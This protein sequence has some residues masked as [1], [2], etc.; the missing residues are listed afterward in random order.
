MFCMQCGKEINETAKFCYSC[1][2]GQEIDESDIA[3]SIS[4]SAPIQ[5]RVPVNVEPKSQ[6]RNWMLVLMV[7]G[8]FMVLIIANAD[9]LKFLDKDQQALEE[10]KQS[11]EGQALFACVG[12]NGLINW[13]IFKSDTTEQ[14][15]RVIE[16]KLSK[17]QEKFEI[18]YLYNL[19]TKVKEI[20][21]M[22]KDGKPQS[23]FLGALEFGT[24][25]I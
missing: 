22:S 24:F 18:Q 1:G 21:F 5:E 4:D 12:A 3:P 2:A 8:I 6:G 19:E 17:R 11:T 14:N 23:K 25:C 10:F 7:F 15:V 16:A 20:A 13:R 9:K